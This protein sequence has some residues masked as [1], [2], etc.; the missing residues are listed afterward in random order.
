MVKAQKMLKDRSISQMELLELAQFPILWPQ[1]LPDGFS[2]QRILE[3][4]ESAASSSNSGVFILV[5]SNDSG[6]WLHIQQSLHM[7]PDLDDKPVTGY[8]QIRENR[9]SVHQDG[10]LRWAFLTQGDVFIQLLFQSLSKTNL[11]QIEQIV[12]SLSDS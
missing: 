9:I 5:Y 7:R 11:E 3:L 6:N 12:S 4:S 2:L 8:L 1:S 10:L